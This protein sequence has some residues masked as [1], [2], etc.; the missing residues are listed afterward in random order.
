M[1]AERVKVRPDA[2][3]QLDR[4]ERD[5]AGNRQVFGEPAHPIDLGERLFVGGTGLHEDV[6]QRN[7]S[8][9]IG[10]RFGE[11]ACGE[12][13]VQW[14]HVDEPVVTQHRGIPEVEVRVE[15]LHGAIVP[16]N[17]T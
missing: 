15:N 11:L 9:H 10:R 3:T 14:R 16:A 4:R 5:D 7:V 13:S 12:R 2:G 1:L 17:P 6:L 8:R